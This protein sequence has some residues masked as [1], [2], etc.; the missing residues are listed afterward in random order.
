MRSWVAWDPPHLDYGFQIQ[1]EID[2]IIQLALLRHPEQTLRAIINSRKGG[3]VLQAG[4]WLAGNSRIQH[5]SERSPW[6]PPYSGAM[7][8]IVARS[9]TGRAV[10]PGP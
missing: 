7:L 1:F 10:A 6:S 5:R 9:T 8:A 3:N 4:R 2:R